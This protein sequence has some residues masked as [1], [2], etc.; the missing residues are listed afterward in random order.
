M[1]TIFS[2]PF[3]LSSLNGLHGFTLNGVNA[4]DLSGGA[5]ASGDFNGDGIKDLAIAAAN[6]SPG[7]Q[8]LAGYVAI[9]FGKKTPWSSVIE[10]ASLDGA[11]GSIMTGVINSLSG[12]SLAVGDLN[13]D[14]I[15]DLVIGGW[16]AESIGLSTNYQSGACY[17]VFG[18][19]PPW[20]ASFSLSSLDGRNGFILQALSDGGVM[21]G[22]GLCTSV[23]V[24]DLNGDGLADLL[25]GAPAYWTAAS[26]YGKVG[27]AVALYGKN[28]TWNAV[29]NGNS[30]DGTNGVIFLGDT[31][32][33]IFG[34]A[35]AVGDLNADGIK[36]YIMS[37]PN[38]TP[39]NRISKSGITYVVFGRKTAFGSATFQVDTVDG[40]DGCMFY[41]VN[42]DD[43]S[44]LALAS[45]K[46]INGDKIDDLV[47]AA[48]SVSTNGH[49]NNGN[50]Y[51]YFGKNATW[52]AA[53][54]LSTLSGSDGFTIWGESDGDHCGQSVALGNVNG[55]KYAD[56]LLGAPGAYT[57]TGRSYLLYGQI[58]WPSVLD[59][60]ASL[61]SQNTIGTIFKGV[62]TNDYTGNAVGF[63][64]LNGDGIDDITIGATGASPGGRNQAGI[65]YVAFGK[66]ASAII[67]Q[68]SSSSTGGIKFSSST[69]STSCVSCSPS[70]TAGTNPASSSTGLGVG[71]SST[72]TAGGLRSSSGT[73]GGLG[74]STG[75]G[76]GG[77]LK[78]SSTGL[79][80]AVSFSSSSTAVNGVTGI[81]SSSGAA[82]Q[83]SSSGGVSGVQQSSSG[84]VSGAA[85]Q[86]S[87]GSVTGIKHSSSGGISGRQQSSSGVDST[88]QESGQ[89]SG[90][91]D[92][93]SGQSYTFTSSASKV[94]PWIFTAIGSAFSM[95]N[96]YGKDLLSSLN[97]LSIGSIASHFTFEAPETTP[98]F[99]ADIPVAPAPVKESDTHYEE[100]ETLYSDYSDEP[101]FDEPRQEVPPNSNFKMPS[102]S[103]TDYLAI[104]PLVLH[105]TLPLLRKYSP[106][107]LPWNKIQPL[108]ADELEKLSQHYTL[109]LEKEKVREVQ[110]HSHA[111]K[112]GLFQDISKYIDKEIA[113]LKNEVNNLLSTKKGSTS[114]IRDVDDRMSRV[115]EKIHELAKLN[116][117][118][119]KL[120]VKIKRNQRKHPGSPT[121]AAVSH[122]PIK[123]TLKQKLV[124]SHSKESISYLLDAGKA[125]N[126]SIPESM[127]AA[128]HSKPLLFS[129]A[130]GSGAKR[131]LESHLHRRELRQSAKL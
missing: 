101:R 116:K 29:I 13:G 35:V 57:A 22:D 118:I 83:Q 53:V 100:S 127:L 64:D 104:A 41:G 82:I 86:S 67:V 105:H 45:G 31:G 113:A 102:L 3:L 43:Q 131:D 71:S 5:F 75:T 30:I 25:A 94:K 77:G 115:Q 130:L 69:G 90:Y 107:T 121:I 49:I 36:D 106:I 10:L 123:N 2:N 91:G 61:E 79:T 87:S 126:G 54:A 59:L 39:P 6:G 52:T 112:S 26:S 81:S 17:V 117:D 14:G 80:G 27:A 92:S 72:G 16:Q 40:S 11:S 56:I 125:T 38:N 1:S 93:S 8:H 74:S 88:G 120:D 109:L 4:T 32:S 37:A 70:S 62:N 28:T 23:V 21:L 111:E 96:S 48:P 7:G 18:H 73:A 46:D 103:K 12:S 97:P 33:D 98:S 55:D 108:S 78:S 84:G 63:C 124:S 66:N 24:A 95:A 122:D 68:P 19:R 42:T 119:K 20:S 58:T 114:Q 44:G 9:L 15:D 47:I 50:V 128:S 110:K 89:N 51:V 76:N 65:S 99:S 85:Q 34:Q 60:Y 129:S